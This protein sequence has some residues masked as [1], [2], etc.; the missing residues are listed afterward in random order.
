MTDAEIVGK[1]KNEMKGECVESVEVALKKL[2]KYSEE[3]KASFKT[4]EYQFMKLD[5][6]NEGV[7][8]PAQFMQGID[9][10]G[11]GITLHQKRFLSFLSTLL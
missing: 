4:I 6:T 3:N 7:L 10:L 8:T 2:K 5:T 11:L 1:V 9:Q